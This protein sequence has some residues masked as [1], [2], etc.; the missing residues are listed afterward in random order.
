MKVVSL[1]IRSGGGPRVAAI[2]DFIEDHDPDVVVLTEWRDTAGGRSL[3]AWATSRAMHC[4]VL[5]NGATANGNLVA[6]RELLRDGEPHA[7]RELRRAPPPPA[8]TMARTA[9]SIPISCRGR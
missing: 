7:A 3:Q 2:R 4:A 6:A 5:N 9:S 8:G 1:N